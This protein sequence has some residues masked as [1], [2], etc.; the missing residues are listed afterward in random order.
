LS[1]HIIDSANGGPRAQV[2]VE[3][4]DQSE[5]CVGRGVSDERGRIEDLASSLAPGRFRITWRVGGAFLGEVSATIELADERHY[6]VPVLA[7][8]GSVVIYLGA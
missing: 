5:A 3:V 7:A 1:T 8:D 4:W 2:E 6:H